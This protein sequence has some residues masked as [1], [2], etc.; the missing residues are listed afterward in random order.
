MLITDSASIIGTV[1]PSLAGHAN[2]IKELRN[3]E[4]QLNNIPT[5]LCSWHV[6]QGMAPLGE[7]WKKYIFVPIEELV[8]DH[9]FFITYLC[10]LSQALKYW[11]KPCLVLIPIYNYYYT[12]N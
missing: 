9:L 2:Y 5:L 11:D 12:T 7:I 1:A 6:Q 8:L 3:A 10:I 4:Q